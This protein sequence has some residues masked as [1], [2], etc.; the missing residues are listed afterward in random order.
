MFSRLLHTLHKLLHPSPMRHLKCKNR[1]SQPFSRY[2]RRGMLVY[3]PDYG[4]PFTPQI[5]PTDSEIDEATERA[6][7]RALNRVF[8]GNHER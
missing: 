3:H 6:I 1:V 5:G 7:D 2:Y 4:V 8:G